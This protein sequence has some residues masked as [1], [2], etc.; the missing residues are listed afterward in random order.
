M[1]ISY[2]R[3]QYTLLFYVWLR[4]VR[5]WWKMRKISLKHKSERY[6]NVFRWLKFLS[7]T[8]TPF[9][10]HRIELCMLR[11]SSN[12]VHREPEKSLNV[13]GEKCVCASMHVCACAT[14]V[15]VGVRVKISI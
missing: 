14:K 6:G 1:Y 3:W 5:I 9:Y 12:G 4:F 13:Y 7:C 2:T 10:P 8:Q 11:I 15:G